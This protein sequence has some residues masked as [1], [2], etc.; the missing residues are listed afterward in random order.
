MNIYIF[1]HV[2]TYILIIYLYVELLFKIYTQPTI[3]LYAIYI[4]ISRLICNYNLVMSKTFGKPV[5]ENVEQNSWP[6]LGKG[7][8]EILR[9][10]QIN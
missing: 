5:S 9:E 6:F 7:I 4:G 1:I 3:T 2:C 8:P 10:K